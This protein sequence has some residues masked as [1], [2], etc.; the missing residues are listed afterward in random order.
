MVGMKIKPYFRLL[1][2]YAMKSVPS[3]AKLE[4]PLKLANFSPAFTT[5]ACGLFPTALLVC[6]QSYTARSL[7]SDNLLQ[8]KW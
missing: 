6:S 8:Q 3:K 7:Q 4:R 1:I 5:S 2:A